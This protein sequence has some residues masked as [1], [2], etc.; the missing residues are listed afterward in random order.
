MCIDIESLQVVVGS[1]V[2]RVLRMARVDEWAEQVEAGRNA[3]CAACRTYILHA[4]GKERRVQIAEVGLLKTAAEVRLVVGELH[5]M[6]LKHV[7]RTAYR[8]RTAVAVLGH[9]IST[10]CNDECRAGRNVECVL[11]VAT[12]THDVESVIVIKIDLLAC[13]EQAIAEAEQLID[14]HASCLQCHEKRCYL[15]V[16]V[17]LLCDANHDVVSLAARQGLSIDQFQ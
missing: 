11:A 9:L 4:I 8:S 14:G 7:R 2:E 13:F 15:A 6:S 3:H 1:A 5:A 12:G 16:V 17:S 10:C